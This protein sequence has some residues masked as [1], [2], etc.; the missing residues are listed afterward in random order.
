MTGVQTCALPI[1]L[2]ALT[3]SDDSGMSGA[4]AIPDAQLI[5]TEAN[6]TLTAAI[7][8]GANWPTVGFFS[9][10]QYVQVSFVSSGT[11]SGATIVA[12]AVKMP[13]LLPVT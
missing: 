6:V 2:L 13:E 11:S 1:Y 12:T 5:G 3:E 4:T 10:K 8:A 9:T 7:V